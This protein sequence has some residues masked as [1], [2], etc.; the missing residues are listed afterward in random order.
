MY[1]HEIVVKFKVDVLFIYQIT[2]D[3]GN[4]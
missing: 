2:A 4:Y 3:G 1:A